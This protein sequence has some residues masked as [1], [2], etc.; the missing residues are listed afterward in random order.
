MSDTILPLHFVTNSVADGLAELAAID[1]NVPEHIQSVFKFVSVR[2][3]RIRKRLIAA[4]SFSSLSLGTTDNEVAI[5]WIQ[6]HRK[7]SGLRLLVLFAC[8]TYIT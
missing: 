8:T 3:D 2:A 5:L 7:G 4:H 6:C 1:A